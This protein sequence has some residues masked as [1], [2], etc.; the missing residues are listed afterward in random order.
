M[1]LTATIKRS[2]PTG[3]FWRAFLILVIPMIGL[4]VVVASVFIQR[5]YDGVTEQMARSVAREINHAIRSVEAAP[6][7]ETAQALLDA[8]AVPFGLQMGLDVGGAVEVTAVRA[9]Y[10]L[11]GSVIA[12]TLSRTV[13]R[14][15]A[16]DFL[17]VR[18]HLDARIQTGT[19]VLRVLI[20]RARM[21]AANPHLLLVWMSATALALTLVASIFLRNQ[22][23]PIRELAR[24]ATAFGRGRTE[25]FRP[26]GAEEVRRAGW[27]F[28]DMRQR[29]ER[30]IGQRTLML[31]GVSH[32]LRTPLTRMRLA[33]AVFEPGPEVE[34]LERD[35]IE[36][37]RMLAAFLDFAR[38]E[39]G[40]EPV[41][42]D[43]VEIAAEVGEDARR[44]G[45][46]LTL[47]ARVDTSEVRLV[48][49][50]RG[51]IKRALTNLVEKDARFG[52]QVR[53]STRLTR[54]ALEFAV[55]DDGPGIP[56]ERREEAV[57]PFTRLDAARN[58]D[59]GSGVGLGLSIALDIAR[60]HG[61]LLRLDDSPSLGGLR[62]TVHL[63]R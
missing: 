18:K 56:P 48:T 58:Q 28:L 10:D 17:S 29:I 7:P 54:R 44:Q 12:E 61:G 15:M 9:F 38:G 16:L 19:G 30:Q 39:G 37:E 63:P 53:L 36:M 14:P 25:H 4:Q 21:N 51:A 35:V 23:K 47:Y 46:A 34:E 62:A 3:L 24:A 52:S 42:L 40:E 8:M 22:I 45:T 27:A 11:T 59:A 1:S 33:L 43:P 26:A 60:S 13:E 57:R 55:E 49:L 2:L 20:P 41:G 5:H 31:S 50:R 6:D 32:D